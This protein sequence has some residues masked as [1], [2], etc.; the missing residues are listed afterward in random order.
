ML[1][2][3]AEMFTK[4]KL[5]K[6]YK[7][8]DEHPSGEETHYHDY[9]QIWYVVKGSCENK[10]EGKSHLL[11]K[12]DIF[13]IPPKIEHMT[14]PSKNTEIICCE[15]S[16][17]QFFPI[18]K[19]Q[20]YTDI[21][22]SILG[23]SSVWCFLDEEYDAQSCLKLQPEVSEKVRLKMM[24]MLVEYGNGEIYYEE[25]IRVEIMNLLILLSREYKK[26]P[27]SVNMSALHERYKP[28]V[29][30]AI[31]YVEEHY[32]E[33][34]KLEDLCRISMVS[35]TYFCYLFKMITQRTFVEYVIELRIQRAVELL[36]DGN[37]SITW[38]G[39]EVGFNDSTHFS[40]TFKKLQGV[41]PR[42][43]RIM[44]KANNPNV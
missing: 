31:R 9:M 28:M 33:T 23:L 13:I 43:Y 6:L 39:F 34:L 8:T 14:I 7:V 16:Y 36:Q 42:T 26:S 5:C 20:L 19:R 27:V 37:N 41:S 44:Q 15:F 11:G 3:K 24:N 12:G 38:V 22:Q 1:F 32:A 4:S 35:K 10:V 25:L 2:E 17:E 29:D 18:Q 30:E 40:R 21:Y